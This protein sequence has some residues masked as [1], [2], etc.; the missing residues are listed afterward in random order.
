MTTGV[1]QAKRVRTFAHLAHAADGFF[2]FIAAGE[3][4]NPFFFGQIPQQARF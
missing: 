1:D 3:E 4:L 2:E